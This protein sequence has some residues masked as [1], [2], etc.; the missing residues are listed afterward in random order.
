MWRDILDNMIPGWDISPPATLTEIAELERTLQVPLPDEL[1]EFLTEINGF[2]S[3]SGC[4]FSWSTL[5]IGVWN[6]VFRSN[7]ETKEC[8][9]PLDNL[10]F[11]GGDSDWTFGYAINANGEVVRP[12]IYL[13]DSHSDNRECV[14]NGLQDYLKQ[15]ASGEFGPD[16][17]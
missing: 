15:C 14:A 3:P 7:Q 9:M 17:C 5:N 16:W 2:C 10:L 6:Q 13:W 12:D 1:K 11:F 4:D 8:Y